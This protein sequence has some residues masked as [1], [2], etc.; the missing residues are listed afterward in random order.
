MIGM[1][2][3]LCIITIM[4]IGCVTTGTKV[5]LLNYQPGLT[6]DLNAYKGKRLYLMNFDNQANDTTIWSY[7]SPDKSVT[8]AGNSAIHNYFWYAFQDALTKTGML[9]SKVD[10]PDPNAPAMALTLLS[11][12]DVKYNV[13]VTLQEKGI[14]VFT[15]KYTTEEAP[16]PEKDRNPAALEQRAYKMTNQLIAKILQ[17]PGVKKILLKS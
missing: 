5:S 3:C 16:L 7:S 13:Q 8:Y 2:V 4:A 15:A 9:I 10:N 17:D 6:G 1:I 11:I 14:T 12:T